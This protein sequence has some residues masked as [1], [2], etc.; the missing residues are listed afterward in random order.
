MGVG[1]SNPGKSSSSHRGGGNRH[2]GYSSQKSSWSQAHMVSS[3]PAAPTNLN[4]NRALGTALSTNT[5]QRRH[6]QKATTRSTVHHPSNSSKQVIIL[7]TDQ[8]IAGVQM[9][10]HPKNLPKSA[11]SNG[12]AVKSK[13]D[14]R[15]KEC[16]V[17]GH[18]GHSTERCRHRHNSCYI[19]HEPGHLASVCTQKSHNIGSRYRPRD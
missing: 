4:V 7:Q 8:P 17:C 2:R 18:T 15:N 1:S 14:N 9:N 19:C 5:G 13:L 11:N 12:A 16:G 6:Q 3:R 10:R